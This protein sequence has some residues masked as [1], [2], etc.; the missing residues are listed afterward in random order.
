MTE[1]KI[2]FRVEN[3]STGQ[4]TYRLWM[5][6]ELM[7]ERTFWPD[8]ASL[9]IDETCYVDI[10]PGNHR[11]IFELIGSNSGRCEVI[12]VMLNNMENGKTWEK[13][14]QNLDGRRQVI[15][16]NIINTVGETQ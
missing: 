8:A 6:N 12:K 3:K 10:E 11:A 2:V 5:D 16:I 15:D 14:P 7:C 4:P 1:H 13:L 9:Y